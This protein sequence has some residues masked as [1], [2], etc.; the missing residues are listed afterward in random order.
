MRDFTLQKYALVLKSIKDQQLPVY[1]LK[2]W[3]IDNPDKGVLIR[4]DVDRKPSNAL[5]MA[6]LEQELELRT[7]YYFR[8]VGSAYRPDIIREIAN[9]GHEVGY[10]YEDL[11]LAGGNV[12]DAHKLF[13]QHLTDLREIANVETIAM[14]GS[15]LSRHNNLDMWRTGN[16]SDYGLIADAFTSVDYSGI[17]Y[18]T[19]TGRSWGAQTTNLR[20]KPET[21]KQTEN[22]VKTTDD[23]IGFLKNNAPKRLAISAHP[24]RWA[25]KPFDWGNQLAKDYGVNFVK[26]FL[27]LIR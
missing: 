24:E 10:H 21:M 8:V 23:L 4:H 14:H 27:R 16:I 25:A 19:D 17:P 3:K 22:L 15:P 1:G 2:N 26:R 11:T 13:S 7:T 5:S 20:D 12:I 6:R 18:F 9:L